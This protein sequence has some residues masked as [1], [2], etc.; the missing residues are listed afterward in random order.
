MNVEDIL[1]CPL[2][3]KE[4]SETEEVYDIEHNNF[5]P[6]FYKQIEPAPFP[7]AGPFPTDFTKSE[8]WQAWWSKQEAME[9]DN[10]SDSRNE[11]ADKLREH[12]I[13]N[14]KIKGTLLDIGCGDPDLSI[15]N[16]Y[17]YIDKSDYVGFDPIENT[18][19]NVVCGLA[20]YLPFRDTSFDN[21]AIMTVLDH[22][23][24]TNRSLS[25]VSRIL[26]PGGKLY[27]VTLVW[28]SNFELDRDEFHFHHFAYDE[29]LDHFSKNGFSI[30]KESLIP[31]KQDYRNAYFFE[32]TKEE[33]NK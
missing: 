13:S 1:I 3:R 7:K 2:T 23:I 5:Y 14:Y 22:I 9:D 25:E 16:Y 24:N 20:E 30:T 29:L 8:Y 11:W 19:K 6:G 17:P 27:I 15:K 4:L 31:W 32:L 12:F 10:F 21:A 18:D 28:K 26:K 33:D